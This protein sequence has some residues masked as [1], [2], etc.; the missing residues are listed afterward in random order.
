[1][2]ILQVRTLRLREMMKEAKGVDTGVNP[3]SAGP[4]TIDW[5]CDPGKAT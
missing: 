4:S 1:M 5:L 2:P 3:G